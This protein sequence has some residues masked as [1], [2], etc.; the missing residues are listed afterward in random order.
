MDT[1]KTKRRRGAPT[2]HRVTIKDLARQLGLSITT[3]SRAL[4]GYS[5]VGEATRQRVVEAAK[6]T[7]YRPNRSARRLVMKRAHSFGWVRPD[8]DG[9]F[10]DPHFVEVFAGTLRAA[11]EHNYD[12]LFA[13]ESDHSP[14]D[15]YDRYIREQSVDGFILELP[16]PG[17]ERIGMLLEAGVPFVV[18]GREGR[19]GRYGWVDIDNRGLFRALTG[20]M[21]EAGHKRLAFINGDETFSYALDRRIGVCEALTERG[22]APKT[23]RILNARHP[24]GQFGYQ[25]TE[26]ALEDKQA[27]AI[28]YSSSI[29]AVEGQAAIARM[30]RH[31][32]KDIAVATMD[33]ELR[34]VDL[35]PYENVFSFIRSSLHSA[36]R[37]L[38]DELIR[39]C[40]DEAAPRGTLIE[41]SFHVQPD[42]AEYLPATW[43][44]RSTIG[45]GNGK[46]A[47]S[48]A[49]SGATDTNPD[50]AIRP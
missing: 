22:L 25:L 49:K 40:E 30:G 37:A 38:A 10:A 45:T 26:Q 36:G 39:Q 6:K 23:V 50:R 44:G 48:R 31:V 29:M 7:G 24:M 27:T 5:D 18:H 35:S 19:E 21:I 9:L 20:A 14:T 12:L 16:H 46:G 41:A 43:P 11:R 8:N 13:S 15:A 34:Y 47:K 28:I 42:L 1:E 17:D 4:N 33:D 32:G 2:G 3:I